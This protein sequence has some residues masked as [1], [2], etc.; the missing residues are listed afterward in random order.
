MEPKYLPLDNTERE[1]VRKNL[2]SSMVVEAGAGTGKTS[3]LIDR[4]VALVKEH[5]IGKIAAIT[6]TEKA[7]GELKDRLRRELECQVTSPNPV[8]LRQKLTALDEIDVA[9]LSTIH[10]FA[11][12]MV[13]ERAIEAGID[14][15]FGHIDTEEENQ[16]LHDLIT[17]ELL[18]SNPERD[19]LLARYLVLGGRLGDLQNLVVQ[20]YKHRELLSDYQADT[21]ALDHKQ[22]LTHIGGQV[23]DLAGN[24]RINCINF[25]DKGRIQIEKLAG[26][27]PDNLQLSH[28]RTPCHSRE[29]GNPETSDITTRGGLDSRFRGIDKIIHEEIIWEWL[30]EVAALRPSFGAQKSWNL[31]DQCREQKHRLKE[32]KEETLSLLSDIR[33]ETLEWIVG[34]LGEIVE[35]VNQ[36]KRNQSRIDFQDQ[37]IEARRLLSNTETLREFQTRYE[38]LLID[39]FQDTDPL[40]VEIALL[41]TSERP[42]GGSAFERNLEPGKLCIVGDPKQSI[43][44][45]R[46]ADPD[47]YRLAIDRILQR[48][49]PVRISQNFRSSRGI[50][51]FVNAFFGSFWDNMDGGKITYEPIIAD[52]LR[53]DASDLPPV[54]LVYPGRSQVD[55]TAYRSTKYPCH[56]RES[57]NDKDDF[58]ANDWD[59]GSVSADEVRAAEANAIA[60]LIHQAHDSN[61]WR[62][63]NPEAK[64]RFRTPEWNDIAVLFPT[65]TGID[66]YGDA[67]NRLGIPFQVEGGKRFF[68]RQIITGLY[69]CLAAVDNPADSLSVIAALRSIYFGVSD[70]DLVKWQAINSGDIDYR[71]IVDG[72]PPDLASALELLNEL[73]C[74][75]KT[76]T[77]DRLIEYLFEKTVIR[78]FILSEQNTWID[79]AAL[80]RILDHARAWG[81]EHGAGL[82]GF[83]RWLMDRIE[84][85]DDQGTGPVAGAPGG[86][87]LMTIHSAKGLE[88]PIVFLANLSVRRFIKPMVIADRLANRLEISLGSVQ[89]GHF[90]TSGYE[91]AG[92]EEQNADTAE[93]MRL[94]YVAMTR[95][96]DYLIAPMYYKEDKQ[97]QPTG[98]YHKWLVDFLNSTDVKS[99]QHENLWRLVEMPLTI[100][101]QVPI[102]ESDENLPNPDDVWDARDT[103]MQDRRDRL[104]E[105]VSR[106]P[107]TVLPSRISTEPVLTNEK[108]QEEVVSS[109]Y[110]TQLGLA[111][112][113]YMSLC[114]LSVNLDQE[115][116]EYIAGEE[117]ASSQDLQPLI[118]T[119]LRSDIWQE[120]LDS[121]RLWREA[122][123]IAH[124]EEG[125]M[126][127][128]ID[129]VWEDNQNGLHIVDWKT[130]QSDP[131]QHSNQMRAYVTA[132]QQATGTQIKS[133][134]LFY[135]RTGESAVVEF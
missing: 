129:L 85:G 53:P 27:L 100:E 135:T 18:Y 65:T 21:H 69:N 34:W 52:P 13:R 83:R 40:Q 76:V 30:I 36:L 33:R 46:R 61:E 6:F 87:R 126:K 96:R 2:A 70:T 74:K 38:R 15:E 122:P 64:N 60:E 44:R 45:F 62:V 29:S 101:S 128:I 59:P 98:L 77:V 67:L 72:L 10:S 57:G 86:V 8:G 115:L 39:E 84:Q 121:I 93:R 105:A 78:P 54:I 58:Q 120:A 43:Y 116:A 104:D 108:Q 28:S 94:L 48:G 49:S 71:H 95:A 4:V 16:L 12:S 31:A 125:M 112:H 19:Q 134:R 99:G 106:L 133:A 97:G 130:G 24:A 14:P 55:N 127:G 131:E 25:E 91:Q 80:D 41:L 81:I 66:H 103:W 89:R 92:E 32:L 75:R 82:R 37:L 5:E 88:F 7:A 109:I 35:R 20:L 124:V 26:L 42:E 110:A 90:Q 9:Q 113:R 119:C 117:D 132:L 63:F 111:L 114:E 1:I 107:Q 23:R 79:S 51:S 56:S 47:I 3:L 102:Q 17:T 118:E 68:T 73:H 22:L 50:V 123:V 11:A